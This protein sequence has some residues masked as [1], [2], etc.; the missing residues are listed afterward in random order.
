MCL[1]GNPDL[2]LKDNFG[3][4]INYLR[5]S[6]TDRCNLRCL[7]CM[8]D[9]GI[10]SVS[11]KEI[12]TYEE[13]L[14]LI[15]IFCELGINKVR[16]T[17]GEPF[18]RKGFIDFLESIAKS[19]TALSIYITTNGVLT[20]PYLSELKKIGIKGINLSLDTLNEEKFKL[21]SKRDFLKDILTSLNEMFRL[22]IPV[23]INTVVIKD[24]NTDELTAIA[25]IAKDKSI[26]VRF[27]E[28]MPFNG[29]S[30]SIKFISA[31]EI[32]NILQE[33]YTGMVNLPCNN[34]TADLFSIPGFKGKIGIIGSYSRTFC[35]SCNRI[36]ITPTGI[37]KT[38]L[39]D[40]SSLNL[41]DMLRTN[42]SNT[43]IKE[44]II[45]NINEKFNNGFESENASRLSIKNSMAIIGG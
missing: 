4:I 45:N 15:K 43:D 8:P 44:A 14:K 31:R 23:K 17:G 40:N 16:F 21:I 26:E 6:V 36:R 27:I 38:C 29:K 35:N 11:H 39:Y 3:R 7:Y 20:F 10:P 18:V 32:L 33:A 24:F 1:A 34:S 9:E 22:E 12:L 28:Q 5:F 30:N 13:A 42:Y 41:R 2:S 25:A 37:L 19:Y